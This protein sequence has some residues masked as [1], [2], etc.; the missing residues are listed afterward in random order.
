MDRDAGTSRDKP[1][2]PLKGALS[3]L[4]GPL[5]AEPVAGPYPMPSA[6]R[7]AGPIVPGR[8]SSL[9]GKVAI[10][11]GAARGIGRAIAVEFAAN[12]ADVV[13]LDIAGPVSPTADAIP[14]TEAELAE[15]VAC[16]APDCRSGRRCPGLLVQRSPL[17]SSAFALLS[18]SRTD[19]PLHI[20]RRRKLGTRGRRPCRCKLAGCSLK[21]FLLLLSSSPRTRQ[22]L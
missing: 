6:E 5:Q 11:T 15:T 1:L 14:A 17:T 13:A 10:V 8:G 19:H 16:P 21:T 3:P 9:T 7:S 18:R 12:G 4:D 20:L 22:H 2:D